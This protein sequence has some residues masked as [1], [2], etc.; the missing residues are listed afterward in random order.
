MMGSRSG[1]INFGILIHL[2]GREDYTADQLDETP[3]RRLV[4]RYYRGR[5][6]RS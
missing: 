1:S 3:T 4:Q 5:Y 6:G 2:L